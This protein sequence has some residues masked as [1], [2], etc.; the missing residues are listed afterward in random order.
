[1]SKSSSARVILTKKMFLFFSV[2]TTPPPASGHA[3]KCN[4][5]EKAYCVNGGDC[6]FI[7]GIDK[8]ACK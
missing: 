1:M 6:Y 4:D 7:H 8:L 3:R 2:T 5:T